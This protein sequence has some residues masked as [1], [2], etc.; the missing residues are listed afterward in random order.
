MSNHSAPLLAR[1][2]LD[3]MDQ[4]LNQN[5]LT[6]SRKRRLR[7][8]RSAPR[9]DCMYNDDEDVKTDEPPPH[10]SIIPMFR[11]LN[12]NL[13]EVILFFVLYLTTG[14]LCFYLVRNQISGNKTNGVLDAIYFCVVTMTTV[15][16]G[17]LVPSSSTS[18]LLACA[19]VFSGMVLVGHLL[20]RAADYLVERQETLLAKAFD[21]HKTVGPTEIL[22]ELHT[23]LRHKCYVTFLVLVVLVLVGTIFL[24]MFEKMPVIEAFYCVCSTV[25][26]LGYGDRSFNSGTGR[27]FAVFWI[28]TS[29]ICLAQFFLYVAE[30]NAETK[31]RELVKWVL[32]RR[33]TN[34]DLEAADL[35]G[36]GVIVAA[37]FILYKLKEMGKIDEEDID[38]ILQEFEQLDYDD[39]GTLTNSDLILSQTT[40]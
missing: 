23:K 24:V 6:S 26:T 20:S 2:H 40:S 13:R 25:T 22:K 31:Q 18:R 34:N 27:L 9:G 7:R 15:G 19:F 33:I 39:S 1:G 4:D 16:Y 8:C 38:G 5:S 11:D 17:D 36:D 29:T 3:P 30:L 32:T 14:T 10:R 12:P 35:D 21:L 37:E 28:L